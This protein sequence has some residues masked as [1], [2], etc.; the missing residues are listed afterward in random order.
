MKIKTGFVTNSSSTCYI[1][2][3]PQNWE[4]D[5][6]SFLLAYDNELDLGL[7][8]I[9]MQDLYEQTCVVVDTLMQ[10]H[11]QWLDEDISFD[12][13]VFW[14][15]HQ[16]FEEEGFILGSVDLPDGWYHFKPLTHEQIVTWLSTHMLDEIQ[17]N[18]G[19]NVAKISKK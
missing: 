19:C 12:M 13:S 16:I 7:E 8:G 4:L 10:G 1:V 14:A 11:E 9:D 18:G 2:A 17:V 15:L 5:K 6:R 3:I